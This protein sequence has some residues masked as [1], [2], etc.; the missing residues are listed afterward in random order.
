VTARAGL[1]MAGP[2]RGDTSPGTAREATDAKPSLHPSYLWTMLL[3]RIVFPLLRRHC[4][5]PMRL[6]AFHHGQ[7]AHPRPPPA[8]APRVAPAARGPPS[9]EEAFDTH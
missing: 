5:E 7:D 6:I 1:T 4:C 2:P 8:K 9:S 3:A